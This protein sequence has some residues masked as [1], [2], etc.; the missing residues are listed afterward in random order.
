MD[1]ART[2][3]LWKVVYV[4][5]AVTAAG[6]IARSVR[7]GHSADIDRTVTLAIQ[8]RKGKRFA[9][10]MWLA[11]WAGFPPQSRTL[12]FVYPALFALAGLPREA[13]F[14]LAGWGTSGIS[15]AVKSVMRRPR[16]FGDE[17]TIYKANIG[18]TSFPSGHVINYIGVYGT[19]AV[20]LSHRLKSTVLRRLV[21]AVCGAQDFAGWSEPNL[22]R[23]PLV[24]R[25]P[26]LVPPWIE[27]HRPP[28][29]GLQAR[30][31]QVDMSVEVVGHGGA[32]DFFPGNSR[33]SIEKALD[34]G[35]DRIEF[36][37]QRAAGDQ[38]VLVHDDDVK[39]G[40]NR[41]RVRDVSV[42]DLRQRWTGCSPLTR[43]R[44]HARQVPAAD[45]HQVPGLRGSC[46]RGH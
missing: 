14:Q 46:R 17:F 28:Q 27:L 42:N 34:L 32:G 24:H 9:R 43:H 38:I 12:P 30:R 10:L 1:C 25:C 41:R 33:Q 16:P 8:R 22:P 44:D 6:V 20:I 36:D 29:L 21:V 31:A 45:R 5:G 15:F 26:D 19:L 4:A 13:I 18:G 3:K 39:I 37:V 7:Y 35:V 40:A 2:M 23:A 11:S